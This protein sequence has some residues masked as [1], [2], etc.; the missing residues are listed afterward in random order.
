MGASQGSLQCAI[1]VSRGSRYLRHSLRSF[2]KT[3]G[4]NEKPRDT[5]TSDNGIRVR[6]VHSLWSLIFSYTPYSNPVIGSLSFSLVLF[7]QRERKREKR[8]G[9][10]PSKVKSQWTDISLFLSIRYIL[11][12]KRE[13][14]VGSLRRAITCFLSM[15]LILRELCLSPVCFFKRRRN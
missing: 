13:I 6:R 3:H 14:S 2:F 5:L 8:K 11:E 4:D 7:L 12:R 10:C 1:N 9:Y 15:P